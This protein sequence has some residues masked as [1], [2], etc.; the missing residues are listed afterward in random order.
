M[1]FVDVLSRGLRNRFSNCGLRRKSISSALIR[2]FA[3]PRCSTI[4]YCVTSANEITGA[5]CIRLR[6]RKTKIGAHGYFYAFSYI[7]S[8]V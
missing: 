8:L 2:S 3:V 6:E 5:K 1:L 7:I 4:Y